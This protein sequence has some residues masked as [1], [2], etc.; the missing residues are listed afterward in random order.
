MIR[1][2]DRRQ[3]RCVPVSERLAEAADVISGAPHQPV[4]QAPMH[5]ESVILWNLRGR[6]DSDQIVREPDRSTGIDGDAARDKLAHRPLN[7]GDVPLLQ[8]AR[9]AKGKGTAGNCEQREQSAGVAACTTESRG[10]EPTGVDV[11][12]GSSDKRLEPKRGTTRPRYKLTRGPRGKA[13]LQ[14]PDQLERLTARQRPK[15]ETPEMLRR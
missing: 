11:R 5:I 14:H 10:Y 3:A 1:D 13:R 9:I 2:V 8:L 12:S 15:L 7:P 6:R 4:A